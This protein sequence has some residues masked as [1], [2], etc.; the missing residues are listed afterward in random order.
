MKWFLLA[1]YRCLDYK[2]RSR[3]K[4]LWFFLLFMWIV[5]LVPEVFTLFV[6]DAILDIVYKL[7]ISYILD[8]LSIIY[9]VAYLFFSLPLLVRRLHDLDKS[10]WWILTIIPPMLFMFLEGV[11]G[12]NK[13]GKDPLKE[14]G[15]IN[16]LRKFYGVAKS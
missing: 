16:T 12:S 8:I 1:I 2:G 4:E 7:N 5:S 13:F 6:A 15:D 10:G 14:N 11:K 3:R 9:L